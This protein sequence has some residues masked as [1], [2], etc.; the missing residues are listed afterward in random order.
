[1]LLT[2]KDIQAFF[3]ISRRTVYHWIKKEILHPVRIGGII[4]F[5]KEE[6]D[7]LLAA[8]ETGAMARKTRVLVID[9]D[10]LVRYSLSHLLL[11]QGY[12]VVVVASGREALDAISGACFDLVVSDYRMPEMNGVETLHALQKAMRETYQKPLRAVFLTA[13]ADDAV[14]TA[15]DEIG[16]R[17]VVE[18]PFDVNDFVQVL[19][20]SLN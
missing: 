16:V 15:A 7:A 13:Y 2:I 8:G 6:I 14:R 12:E 10:V 4:R 19:Q 11:K 1:M 9:D 3:K 17:A 5:R 20:R 18:K